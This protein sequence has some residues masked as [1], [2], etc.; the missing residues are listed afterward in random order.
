MSV[1]YLSVFIIPANTTALHGLGTKLRLIFGLS[2]L[3]QVQYDL[4]IKPN[5]QIR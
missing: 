4:Q 3:I 2:L 5:T 1:S